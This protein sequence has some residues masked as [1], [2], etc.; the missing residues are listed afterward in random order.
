MVAKLKLE[1]TF[2]VSPLSAFSV[3]SLCHSQTFENVLFARSVK[4]YVI[5]NLAHFGT[6]LLPFYFERAAM[7]TSFIFLMRLK[8]MSAGIKG[9]RKWENG[10]VISMVMIL[11]FQNTS[12]GLLTSSKCF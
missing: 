6:G 3:N 5:P 2:P 8:K 4:T 1:P 7:V 10:G 11:S 12:P 9:A